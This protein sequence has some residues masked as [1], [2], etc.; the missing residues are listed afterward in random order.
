MKCKRLGETNP[1]EHG[2]REYDDQ[3]LVVVMTH[4][5]D[6]RLHS[7][8]LDSRQDVRRWDVGRQ[9]DLEVLEQ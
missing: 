9:V 6:Q 4:L 8:N 7:V 5:T 2:L 3:S 1:G